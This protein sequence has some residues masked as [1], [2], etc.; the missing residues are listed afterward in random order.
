MLA[1]VLFA[2]TSCASLHSLLGSSANTTEIAAVT[3]Y[4]FNLEPGFKLTSP[5]GW[6][7]AGGAF[8]EL[9]FM[10]KD[11][12]AVFTVSTVDKPKDLKAVLEIMR[13]QF[14]SEPGSLVT[15]VKSVKGFDEAY[16]VSLKRNELV[17]R[18]AAINHGEFT[19]LVQMFSGGTAAQYSPMDSMLS[20]F[21]FTK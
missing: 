12:N 7:L 14:G 6:S 5:D 15:A 13:A 16:E 17:I 19:Y 1:L 9:S 18:F 2:S 4:K 20:S 11:L 10:N 8:E 3:G 21:R